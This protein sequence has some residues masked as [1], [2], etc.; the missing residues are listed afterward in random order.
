M[1]RQKF[2]FEQYLSVE[3]PYPAAHIYEKY[4]I[5]EC[6]ELA[7]QNKRKRHVYRITTDGENAGRYQ[8]VRTAYVNA[9]A[10]ALS[11]MK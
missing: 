2:F 4:P 10:K 7:D 5:R 11:G 6:Q 1:P 8:P 3:Q 9:D